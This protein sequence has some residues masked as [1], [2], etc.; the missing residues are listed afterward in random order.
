MKNKI[1][2]IPLLTV[3][4]AGCATSQVVTP[5]PQNEV[6]NKLTE[7]KQME[8]KVILIKTSLGDIKAELY[9]DKAPVTVENFIQYVDDGFYNGTIFHRVMPGF[10]VQGGGFTEDRV[11]KETND[12]IKIESDN[13]LKNDRGTLAMARTR[14]PDSATS[15]FFVNLVDNDFLN[16]RSP[17]E[18][19][20][21]YTV[22]GKVIEGMDVVDQ[23]AKVQTGSNGMHQDWPVENVVIEKVEVLE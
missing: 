13:G 22:F 14:I 16:Y 19:G 18:D 17:D 23:I 3:L 4:I 1:L 20:Y 11:Q 7:E 5:E 10:M 6:N 9:P 15:Q 21:G 12:A 8:T 2:L